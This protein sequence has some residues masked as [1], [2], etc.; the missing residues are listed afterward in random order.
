MSYS[1]FRSD[2]KHPVDLMEDVAIGHGYANFDMQII[3][4]VTQ[5]E[6]LPEETLS[7][8]ARSAMLGFGFDEVLTLMQQ[9]ETNHFHRLRLEPADYA[10]LGNPK[11]ADLK[12]LRTHLLSGLLELLEQNKRKPAPLRLFEIGN[13]IHLD[14]SQETGTIELRR[15]AFMVMGPETGYAEMRATLDGLLQELGWTGSYA[16]LESPSFIAGRAASMDAGH[17]RRATLGELHPEVITAFGLPYPVSA[18]E[19]DLIRV[20]G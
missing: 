5:A 2:V 1:A 15:L 17:E 10:Q 6:E 16:P 8:L 9:T 18:C 4:S 20:I 19:L 12:V 3:P 7:N 11:S 13:V 14:G